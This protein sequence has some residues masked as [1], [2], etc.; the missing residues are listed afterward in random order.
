MKFRFWMVLVLVILSVFAVAKE[1]IVV[2]SYISD[3]APRIVFAELVKMFEEKYPEYDVVVNTFPH[4][5][6]K[7]LLRT[8]LNSDEAPDVV[9]WF[10]GE[11]MRYFASKGL[12]EPVDDIFAPKNF[13]DYFPTSFRSACEYDGR[14]YFVPQSWYWWGVYY[15]KSVFE[16]YGI[17]P[18]KT[19]EEFIKVC[20]TLKENGIT[21]I[22]IG[23]KYLWPAAGWFDYLDLRVNGLDFHMKLTA[24]EIPYTD[25]RVKEVFQYWKELVEKGFFLENHSSYTWQEAAAFLFRGEAGMYLIGQF[26]KDVAPES[27]KDDLDFFRFP[28][29]KPEIGLYEETPIDGFMIP[30]RAKNKEGAKVFLKFIAEKEVQEYFAKKLGRLAANKNV[31]PADEHA[32]KGLKMILESDGVAQF[33]DRDT[34]PEMATAGMNGFVEFM[35]YPERLDQILENLERERQ[36][37]FGK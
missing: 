9:T 29:I 3:P 10:T 16:K 30:A 24:G 31:E 8:W 34:N 26:I 18:P 2:N 6:F 13:E 37:I 23:T 33:Y 21:P 17:T 20:E 4:E 35:I 12:L 19:W 11:R 1:K 25:P 27:V 36:R 22:T 7:T 32:A 28:I 5:D 14:I 15:R